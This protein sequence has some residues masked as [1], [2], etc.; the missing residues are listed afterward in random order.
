MKKIKRKKINFKSIKL[1]LLT[2]IF[3]I[4]G[5]T[6][7]QAYST[8]QYYIDLPRNYTST[9][10]GDFTDSI[11]GTNIIITDDYDPNY[12]YIKYDSNYLNIMSDI[13]SSSKFQDML[14]E[15][16]PNGINY[17]Y[18]LKKKEVTRFTKNNYKCFYFLHE[19]KIENYKFCIEQYY[20][21]SGS[22][23]YY[24][25]ITYI[26]GY[27]NSKEINKIIDSFTIKNFEPVDNSPTTTDIIKT[28]SIIVI[29]VFTLVFIIKLYD[30]KKKKR[31]KFDKRINLDEYNFNNQPNIKFAENKIQKNEEI[32]EEVTEKTN[33]KVNQKT[34]KEKENQKL[35]KIVNKIE[36][37]VEQGQ[38]YNYNNFSSSTTA[39]NKNED[40]NIIM[41][42]KLKRLLTI[43]LIIILLGSI[44]A[45]IL[46]NKY[47]ILNVIIT[48]IGYMFYPLTCILSKEKYTKKQIKKISIINSLVVGIIFAIIRS[49]TTNNLTISV[50]VAVLYGYISYYCLS[51]DKT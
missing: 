24:V 51:T 11:T 4:F 2:L 48:V 8:S 36:H 20:V 49:F 29:V 41:N 42:K 14:A 50:S 37:N 15:I 35:Q 17:S 38:T 22:T 1:I 21:I 27:E 45:T 25:T 44:G 46:N 3:L 7:I 30:D 6:M 43:A 23:T 9:K 12:R 10:E 28:V 40:E 26:D 32:N 31:D 13:T 33:E 5:T 34:S 18:K 16:V 19:I 39:T 47:I